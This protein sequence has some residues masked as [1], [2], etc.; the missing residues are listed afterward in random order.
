[1]DEGTV[2]A[3][4]GRHLTHR[5]EMTIRHLG[6][7]SAVTH[8]RVLKRFDDCTLLEVSLE[9]GR[10]HQI[11]VHMAHLG[12]GL[13]GDAVYGRRAGAERQMLHAWQLGFT[14]PRSLQWM[15]F[16]SPLPEDFRAAGVNLQAPLD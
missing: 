10:T 14:H 4:I 12:H 7:R 6:G 3:A 1:M 5:K 2:K 16:T 15:Q 11:R 9:T 8:Y 13:L